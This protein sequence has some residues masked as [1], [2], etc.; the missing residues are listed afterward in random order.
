V[1][2]HFPNIISPGVGVKSRPSKFC[3]TG[4]SS[5]SEISTLKDE[6]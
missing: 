6:I 4:F 1:A 5:V 3:T 2:V